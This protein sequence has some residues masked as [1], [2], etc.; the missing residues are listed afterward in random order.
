[1]A[2]VMAPSDMP[3]RDASGRPHQVSDPSG[4]LTP[5]VRKAV[6]DSLFL[7][8]QKYTVELA[9]ALPAEI[10]DADPNEWCEELF[11]T[12]KIGKKDKDNGMLIM[13]SPG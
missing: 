11:S 9:I 3:Y 12:W 6:E 7:I 4:F 8:Y 1:M 13:I 2:Q 5:D 10:G